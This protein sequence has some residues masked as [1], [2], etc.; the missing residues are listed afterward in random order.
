MRE[1]YRSDGWPSLDTLKVELLA[2]GLLAP[3]STPSGFEVLRVTEAGIAELAAAHAGL[4]SE[5]ASC[6]ICIEITKM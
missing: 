3:V 2:K 4:V 5:T 6:T 1:V